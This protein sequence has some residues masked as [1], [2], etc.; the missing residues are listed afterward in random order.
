MAAIDASSL[1]RSEISGIKGIKKSEVTV[2]T[3]TR[4]PDSAGPH[5]LLGCYFVSL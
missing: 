4:K 2:S 5:V 1:T 3:P